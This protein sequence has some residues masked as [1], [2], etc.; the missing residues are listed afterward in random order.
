MSPKKK[1]LETSKMTR[2]PTK[3]QKLP[4]YPYKIKMIKIPLK[5]QN[6]QNAYENQFLV[7]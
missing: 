7:V 4:K 1:N 5:L 3:S 6:E 2:I